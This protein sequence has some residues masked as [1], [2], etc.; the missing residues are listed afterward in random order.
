M[1]VTKSLLCV[2]DERIVLVSLR[3][4]ISKHFG[5]RYRCEMTESTEEAWEIIEELGEDV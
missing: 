5:D 2:Y 1:G 3:D 4:R